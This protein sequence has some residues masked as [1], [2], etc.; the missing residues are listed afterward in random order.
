MQPLVLFTPKITPR[1][2]YTLQ[3]CTQYISKIKI[4]LTDNPNYFS[5]VI[6][7]K[8]SYGQ[9]FE[10]A[11]C[12]Y[13][14]GLLWQNDIKPQ[15]WYKDNLFIWRTKDICGQFHVSIDIF[16]AIFYLVSR[17]EEYLPQPLDIHGRIPAKEHLLVKF[18]L[19]RKAVVHHYW[20]YL[21][22]AS[23]QFFGYHVPV[24]YPEYSAK[25]TF[26]IDH[27][28]EYLRKPKL[29]NLYGLVRDI[30]KG[31]W[32]TLSRRLRTL[33]KKNIDRFYTFEY[34]F[35][36]LETYSRESLWF[37]LCSRQHPLDSRHSLHQKFYKNL[38]QKILQNKGQI[39]LHA[40]YLTGGEYAHFFIEPVS[41]ERNFEPAYNYPYQKLCKE[42]S[43]LESF[44]P[45]MLTKNRQHFLRTKMPFTYQNLIEA[46]IHEDYSMGYFDEVGFRAGIAVPYP[47]FNLSKNTFQ[48]HLM[49]YPLISMDISLQQY[50]EY[51]PEQAKH[52]SLE[53][54]NEVKSVNGTF[55]VL[56]HNNNLHDQ[57]EWKGWREVF[58]YQLSIT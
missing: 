13:A 7:I 38:I 26:D 23:L 27:P 58:E 18:N 28:F 22:E 46:G 3:V 48:D 15:E 41:F 29:I 32:G 16:S 56:W 21:L 37:I 25:I 50:L 43:L 51:D 24:K 8:W 55:I 57:D 4:E 6:G 49:I 5:T 19:H 54:V 10:D 17:Y 31:D 2:E 33:S 52:I 42:K 12:I 39:G 35:K 1:L 44:L 9:I 14:D 34:I 36:Q 47:F 45:Y 40:S 30:A 20:Q 53:L 11:L